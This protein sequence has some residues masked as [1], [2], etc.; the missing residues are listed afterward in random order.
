M[1][2]N[3]NHI[4]TPSVQRAA[5]YIRASTEKQAMHGLSLIAQ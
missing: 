3:K 2:P 1:P 4:D 5:L